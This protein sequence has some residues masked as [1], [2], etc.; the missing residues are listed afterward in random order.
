MSL[1]LFYFLLQSWL[2]PGDVFSYNE[3]T[4]RFVSVRA[5]VHQYVKGQPWGL[6]GLGEQGLSLA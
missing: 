3:F 2:R 5:G 1:S 4:D 6:L